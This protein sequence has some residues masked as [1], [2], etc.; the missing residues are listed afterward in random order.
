MGLVGIKQQKFHRVA[1]VNI[2]K[3]YGEVFDGQLEKLPSVTT[4]QLK[5]DAVPSVMFDRK[6]PVMVRLELKEELNRLTIL[7]V[8]RGLPLRGE[9]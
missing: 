3:N 9:R 7:G 5:L 4:L 2:E 8:S 1:V 6:I